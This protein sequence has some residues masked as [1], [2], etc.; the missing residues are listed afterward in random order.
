[1][2]PAAP[3]PDYAAI[4]QL[5]FDN[6]QDVLD[7]VHRS[8]KPCGDLA[9]LNPASERRVKHLH[10]V[11]HPVWRWFDLNG[12]GHGYDLISLVEYLADVPRDVAATFLRS[13]LERATSLRRPTQNA[14]EVA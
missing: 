9:S 11:N 14:V 5:A 10:I 1:M 4:H 6:L 3:E 2:K 13:H 8:G 7:L 12:S